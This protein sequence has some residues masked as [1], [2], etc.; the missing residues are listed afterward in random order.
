MLLF[1]LWP[2][3]LD[4][5]TFHQ[6]VIQGFYGQLSSFQDFILY[7]EMWLQEGKKKKPKNPRIFLSLLSGLKLLEKGLGRGPKLVAKATKMN[8]SLLCW[9]RQQL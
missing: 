3:Y 7:T 9:A 8:F 4:A 1:A 2:L 6:N 5:G